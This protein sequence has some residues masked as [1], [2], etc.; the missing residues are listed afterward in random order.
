MYIIVKKL[1]YLV[2]TQ[3][4]FVLK[5]QVVLWMPKIKKNFKFY[6]SLKKIEEADTY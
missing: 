6:R 2:H 1:P 4:L 3:Y 5:M